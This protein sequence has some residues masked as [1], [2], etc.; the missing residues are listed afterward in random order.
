MFKLCIHSKRKE[1]DNFLLNFYVVRGL[2][3]FPLYFDSL[4]ACLPQAPL[5]FHIVCAHFNLHIYLYIYG[6]RGGEGGIGY[7]R[8]PSQKE[9][10]NE[11]CGSPQLS[12]MSHNIHSK[13]CYE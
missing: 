12:N 4:N 2:L 8:C 1:N 13:D 7:Q 11:L 10:K 3:F 5:M 9:E 6:G